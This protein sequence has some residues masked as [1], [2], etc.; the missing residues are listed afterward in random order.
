[1]KYVLCLVLTFVLQSSTEIEEKN[2]ILKEELEEHLV[3]DLNR[4]FELYLY[5]QLGERQARK[6]LKNKPDKISYKYMKSN[7]GRD[8]KGKLTCRNYCLYW[9]TKFIEIWNNPLDSKFDTYYEK[10]ESCKWLK[11][12][13]YIETREKHT[14]FQGKYQG[15]FQLEPKLRKNCNNVADHV[16]SANKYRN[17]FINKFY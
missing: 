1:M 10:Y 3:E 14:D 12:V 15:L 17:Y 6:I 4:E 5:F 13:A 16:Y 11:T 8:F 2:I 7:I 9:K